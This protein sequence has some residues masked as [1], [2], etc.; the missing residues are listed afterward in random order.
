[1]QVVPRQSSLPVIARQMFSLMTRNIARDGL[2]FSDP[3]TPGGLSVPGCII[4]APSYPD[5]PV[6]VKQDYGFNWTRVAAVAA[7]ELAAANM[8]T[9]ARDG[10]QSLVDYLNFAKLCINSGPPTVG[11]SCYT[12]EGQPRPWPEQSDGPALQ[13][14][15]ILRAFPH[16]DTSARLTATAIIGMDVDYLLS[17]YQDTTTN[18]W[19]E[20]EGYSFF[21]RAVQL[22]CFRELSYNTYGIP[23]PPATASAVAWLEN[24]LP[25]HWN[26]SY[27]VSVLPPQPGYDPNIDIVMAAVYGAIPYTDTK[28]LATAAQ[29]R[30][31]W[32]DSSSLVFYP[33]NAA[34]NDRGIGPVRGRYP[35]DSYDGDTLDL[36]PGGHPW[37]L[38]TG[39]FAELYY[40]LANVI[41]QTQAVP[42][43]DLSEDFFSLIRINAD[44]P[45]R[46]AV[47][48]LR[49]AG[50]EMLFAIVFHS[51]HLELSE[52]ID[53]TIGYEKSVRNLTWSY[54]A[55]LSAVRA[56]TGQPVTLISSEC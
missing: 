18:L 47:A 9:G 42:F 41:A 24:S 44:T 14:M 21:A 46:D 55:F 19:E 12:I 37:L 33:I 50:D 29:L 51:D 39:N 26:G 38:C 17:A 27:Y 5:D 52:Q 11:H 48:C 45:W 56:K 8:P 13:T 22:R 53:G 35:D 31:Q 6:G 2:L 49:N 54:A 36:V 3:L 4:A 34:D 28:L 7:M 43:D 25:D 23:V 30:R 40:G 1:M 10:A 15:A 32:T 20:K 16:F